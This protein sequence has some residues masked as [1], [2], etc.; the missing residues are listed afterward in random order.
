MEIIRKKICFE[1]YRSRVMG[2]MPYIKYNDDYVSVNYDHNNYGAF[3]INYI[4]LDDN[5]NIKTIHNYMDIML[6]YNFLKSH[7]NNGIKLKRVEKKNGEIWVKTFIEKKSPYDFLPCDILSFKMI[8]ND[9]YVTNDNEKI[10]S[11]YIVLVEDFET[12]LSYGTYKFMKFVE[13]DI[14]GLYYIYTDKI[15]EKYGEPY[16]D[17]TI[18]SAIYEG[19]GCPIPGIK[20]PNQIYYT[21][22]DSELSKMGEMRETNNPCILKEWEEMGGEVYQEILED[23][24][25]LYDEKKKNFKYEYYEMFDDN[26]LNDIIPTIDVELL[27]TNSY[28]DLGLYS[29]Y[30]ESFNNESDNVYPLNYDTFQVESQLQ[31]LRIRD[32]FSDDNG[33]YLPGIFIKDERFYESPNYKTPINQPK[34]YETLTLKDESYNGNVLLKYINDENN[35]MD[36]PFKEPHNG[37]PIFNSYLINKE[38]N[39]YI[40]DFVKEIDDKIK[41]K[42]TFKYVIGGKYEKDING[43]F[44]NYIND[45]SGIEYIETYNYKKYDYLENVTIDGV[46]IPKL[47]YNN[48]DYTTNEK[49]VYNSDLNL[50]RMTKIG[51]ITNMVNDNWSKEISY[52]TPIYKD[53]SLIG[54]T[55]SPKYQIDVEV[56]RGGISVNEKH[57]KLFECNT[58]EDLTNYGNDYFGIEK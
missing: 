21:M 46:L 51:N 52:S 16:L 49:E 31:T 13:E 48:I 1:N 6:K 24:K 17:E 11:E 53:N 18:D 54:I 40:G 8:D 4:E 12:Y 26:K 30:D 36:I 58:F 25:V 57:F 14:I 15:K 43:G 7:F 9:I 2:M 5:G 32:F 55:E 33:E 28:N 37:G 3:P 22:I 19:I 29:S 44:K 20:M 42:I 41:G 56:S 38:L 35:P 10:A 47:Y 50:R 39:Y 23:L 34:N 27:L 45:G